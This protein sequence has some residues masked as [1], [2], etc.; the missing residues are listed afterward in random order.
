MKENQMQ[1]LDFILDWDIHQMFKHRMCHIRRFF[2]QAIA[3]FE[4]RQQFIEKGEAP[5]IDSRAPEDCDGPAF[6]LEWLEACEGQKMIGF[7]C[8]TLVA[9]ALDDYT[10]MF[11][12]RECQLHTDQ[13]F[14]N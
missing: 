5:Y 1:K 4:N 12:V 13:S 9:K 2:E 10:R 3:P 7:L 14:H 8:L 6:E 11:I